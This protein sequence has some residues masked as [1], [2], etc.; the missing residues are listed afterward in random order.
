MPVEQTSS[1]ASTGQASIAEMVQARLRKKSNL[2]S[3]FM[4][5]TSFAQPG[6]KSISFPR[7]TNQFSVQKLSGSQKGDDQEAQFALDELELSEEAHIQWLIKKFDQSRAKV[8]ILQQAINEATDAHGASFG[9]DIYTALV[10]GIPGANK[11]SDGITQD[12]VV[13]LIERAD[14][15]F[16]PMEDRTFSVGIGAYASLLKIDGFVDSSKSNIDIVRSG[17]IGELYGV[18]VI[19]DYAVSKDVMLLTHRQAVAYGFGALPAIEDE[20]AIAYGTGSRRWVMDQLYGVKELNLNKLVV[21][22]GLA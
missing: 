22:Q 17:Q 16:M 15:V 19:K 21:S 5:V 2:A 6:D 1:A 14:E 10:A 13:N 18:P 20:K 9:D 7:W 8:Q 11:L 4:D 12:G 3:A